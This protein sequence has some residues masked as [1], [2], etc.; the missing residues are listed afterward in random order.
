MSHENPRDLVT[1][2][3]LL[4]EAAYYTERGLAEDVEAATD[5]PGP[6]VEVLLRLSR[7]RGG[8]TRMSEMAEQVLFPPSS[9][10][11]LADKMED[12]GLVKREPDPGH[13]RATLLRLTEEGEQRLAAVKAVQEPAL[14]ARIGCLFSDADLDALEVMLRRLRAANAP[15]STFEG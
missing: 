12:A 10:T 2:A 4:F 9:F 7:T 14:Q 6:W 5:L 1:S 8:A 15:G 11:R 13:R 3:G